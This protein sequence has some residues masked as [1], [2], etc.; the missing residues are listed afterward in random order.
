MAYCLYPDIIAVYGEHDSI[1]TDSK[2][3]FAR[4]IARQRLPDVR[5][6]FDGLKCLLNSLLESL[7]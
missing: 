6:V 2:R 7:V 4:K 5:I 3:E 1:L